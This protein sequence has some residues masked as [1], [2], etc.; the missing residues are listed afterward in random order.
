MIK[1]TN[2]SKSYGSRKILNQIDLTICPGDFIGIVGPSGTGK[3]TLLNIIGLLEDFDE[4]TYQ[5]FEHN[6]S[7]LSA[8]KLSALRNQ[9]IG[10]VFQFFY[11]IPHLTV[12]DNILLP[13]VYANEHIDLKDELLTLVKE[14]KIDHL[15]REKVDYLSGGEKQRVALARALIRR[16]KLLICDE[17]TGNLD[18][19]NAQLIF[20]L[21]KA[22]NEKGTTIIMATHDVHLIPQL[23]YIYRINKGELILEKIQKFSHHSAFDQNNIK[24]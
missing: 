20:R 21:L 3:S 9:Y 7:A 11:L 1:L 8:K 22:Q 6:V 2:L 19:E 13:I 17:P 14:L 10:F 5:F 15:L 4:G 18:E 23:P 12:K 24:Q 16:P